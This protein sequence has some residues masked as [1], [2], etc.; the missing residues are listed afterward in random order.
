MDILETNEMYYRMVNKYFSYRISFDIYH[1]GSGSSNNA[2]YGEPDD[3]F[4]FFKRCKP[5]FAARWRLF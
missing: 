5:A 2:F 3:D 1:D 4:Y